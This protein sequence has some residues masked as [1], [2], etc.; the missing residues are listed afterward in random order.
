VLVQVYH[1]GPREAGIFYCRL[2]GRPSGWIF[3]VTD[4]CFPEVVGDGVS[5]LERLILRDRRLRMQWATFARRHA[6][7]LEEV[8]A[9]GERIRLAV[10]G[11]HCQGTM[12]RDGA[13]LATPALAQAIDAVARALPDF[14]FGRFDVRY[15]HVEELAAGRGFA[16]VELNG[17]TSEATNIYDPDWTL[18]AA[19]RTLFRQWSLAYRIGAANRRRGHRPSPLAA[20]LRSAWEHYHGRPASALAD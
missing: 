10:A 6:G 18:L 11:N 20:L 13:R 3:S 5:T 19:Y 17:V 9:D 4:K 16:V 15:A 2:P 8:P 1:P 12:F 7:R 14:H